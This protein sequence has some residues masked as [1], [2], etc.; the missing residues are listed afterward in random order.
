MNQI[1]NLLSNPTMIV[2][3]TAFSLIFNL[4]EQVAQVEVGPGVLGVDA[5]GFQVVPL[6]VGGVL[7]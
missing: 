2:L 6:G 5:D 1:Y 7:Q 4:H 3:A